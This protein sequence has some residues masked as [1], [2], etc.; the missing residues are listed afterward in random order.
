M[1]T[2]LC[3]DDE[4]KLLEIYR[5]VLEGNGYTVLTATNGVAGIA[6][7]RKHSID[8]VVLDFNMPGMDGNQIAHVLMEEHP[9][10]PIVIWSG[11]PD[12][13]PESLKWFADALLYKGDGPDTL[14]PELEK[15][16]TGTVERKPPGR[17]G[18]RAPNERCSRPLSGGLT[19][20]HSRP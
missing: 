12:E 18:R 15:I 20:T 16:L 4:S 9:T 1:A 5:A 17:T 13:I 19:R 3:I 14:L 11:C 10:L 7:A 8:A 6:L 2:I